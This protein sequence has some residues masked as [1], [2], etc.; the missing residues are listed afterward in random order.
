MSTIIKGSFSEEYQC[1]DL[2]V[3]WRFRA[4]NMA[5]VDAV[6]TLFRIMWGPRPV[7][8]QTGVPWHP[9]IEAM[10]QMGFEKDVDEMAGSSYILHY[11][12]QCLPM[13]I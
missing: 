12:V 5:S 1:Q 6:L 2:D 9:V 4:Q 11:E 7:S 3:L 13:R 10:W 8:A